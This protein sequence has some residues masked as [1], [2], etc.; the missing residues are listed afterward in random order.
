MMIQAG[1]YVS[2]SDPDI[3]ASILAYPEID[4]FLTL[5]GQDITTDFAR[6]G[7]AV[8]AGQKSPMMGKS[9]LLSVDQQAGNKFEV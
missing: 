4:N 3:D 9:S 6:L 1:L 5:S 8:R 7:R 2:V